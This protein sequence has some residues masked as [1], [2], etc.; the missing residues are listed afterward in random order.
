MK[1]S[2]DKYT[3]AQFMWTARNEFQ[4]KWDYMRA[5]DKGW[6]NKTDSNP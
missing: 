6:I 5:W 1:E 4:A 3:K 2:M